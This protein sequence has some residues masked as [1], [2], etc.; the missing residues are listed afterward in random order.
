MQEGYVLSY[1]SSA[2]PVFGD[3]YATG[4]AFYTRDEDKTTFFR[5]TKGKISGM[6]MD[7]L[8]GL[9]VVLGCAITVH[10]QVE[11]IPLP[12]SPFSEPVNS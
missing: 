9:S 3:V 8:N 7:M 10:E 11:R 12:Q 1:P 2:A 6:Q 4:Q 5:H